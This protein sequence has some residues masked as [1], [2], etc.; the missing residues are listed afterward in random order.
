MSHRNSAV[1]AL[2]GSILVT[3]AL[4]AIA[5]SNDD[6]LRG[7]DL[8][9]AEIANRIAIAGARRC[10]NLMPATGL[11]ITVI[12]QYPP[13]LRKKVDQI[14]PVKIEGVAPGLAADRAGLRGGDRLLTFGD[15]MLVWLPLAPSPT[16]ATR[17]GVERQIIALPPH[18]PISVEV[19]RDGHSVKA[20]LEP[21]AACRT[22]FEVVETMQLF[23]R[24]DGEMI[25]LSSAYVERFGEDGVA[26][27]FAHEL[28]H[29]VL[30]HRAAIAATS[31]SNRSQLSRQAERD[32]D[33]LSVH[34]LSAAGYDPAIA[35][36]FWREHGGELGRRFF[37]G[38]HDSPGKRIKLLEAEIAAMQSSP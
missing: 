12:D 32:A 37:G 2:L 17:D 3:V 9:L 23:A 25:Q 7:D 8:Q 36:R 35:P 6:R 14:F 15:Q 4:P 10:Q 5:D 21:V 20:V 34:L 16:S 22:R 24:S 38:K 28:A 33:K 19:L 31:G 18:A 13:G 30:G 1:R 11:V 26:V 29:T 27:A